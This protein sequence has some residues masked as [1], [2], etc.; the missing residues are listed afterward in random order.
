MVRLGLNQFHCSLYRRTICMGI[1]ASNF[2]ATTPS[3]LKIVW[4]SVKKES[5]TEGFRV[6]SG[7]TACVGLRAGGLIF[8]G[9]QRILT[10]RVDNGG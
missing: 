4:R 9:E 2:I 10:L 5:D 1:L 7:G 6:R 8:R 3:S